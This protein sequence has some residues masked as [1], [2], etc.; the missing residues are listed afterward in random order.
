MVAN[1]N[2]RINGVTWLPSVCDRGAHKRVRDAFGN[3]EQLPSVSVLTDEL[4]ANGETTGIQADGDGDRRVSR[5]V[6]D[7]RVWKE[8]ERARVEQ[9]CGASMAGMSVAQLPFVRGYPWTASPRG[10]L[11]LDN[12]GPHKC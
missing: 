1:K 11:S 10:D 7:A 12:R 3:A 9:F 5:G 6:E 4:D 2:W 8:R